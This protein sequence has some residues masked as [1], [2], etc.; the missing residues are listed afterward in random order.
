MVSW[1]SLLGGVFWTVGGLAAAALTLLIV[2]QE[3]LIYVPVVPGL[4]REYPYK[5]NRWRMD[6]EDVW[7]TAADGVKLHSWFIK[8]TP[9]VKNAPTIILFQENAGNIAHRLEFV[10]YI[11]ANL[12]CNVYMLSY[13]GYGESEGSP[14]EYGIKQDAQAALEHLLQRTDINTKKLVIF[15]RSLGGAVG[16]SLA[17]NNPGK[18]AGLVIENTFTSILD[19]AGVV[20]PFMRH[21]VSSTGYRPLNA[22]VRSQWRTIDF[23]G[24]INEPMLLLISGRDEL[25]PPGHMRLLATKALKNADGDVKVVEYPEGG[26]MDLWVRAG[27]RY[28]RTIQLFVERITADK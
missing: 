17:H 8:Y 22:V 23:I 9:D 7:L 24:Q 19:M 28:W 5:P 16:T 25:V 6:Y 12:K 4:T 21:A 13:R 1:K 10:R 11:M 20:L 3:K 27:E 2:F 26:H 15:G 14:T 18:V